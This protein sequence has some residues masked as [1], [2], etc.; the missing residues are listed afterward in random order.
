[1]K[2]LLP[3]VRDSI[4]RCSGHCCRSFVL[5]MPLEELKAR[6]DKVWDGEMIADMV[7][8]LED[9]FPPRYTCRHL[10][11]NGDC[12][13]YDRRPRMCSEYPYGGRCMFPGC[14]LE[15]NPS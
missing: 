11:E 13:V 8:H 7:I 12:S 15:G 1:M 5:P 4:R 9:T 10:A 14:T 2:A 6:T 3:V